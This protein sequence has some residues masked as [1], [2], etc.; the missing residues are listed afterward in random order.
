[1]AGPFDDLPDAQPSA[2]P[3]TEY[4]IPK[5]VL[6][7]TQGDELYDS[8]TAQGKGSSDNELAPGVVAVNPSVHPIGTIFKDTDTN[9]VFI[10]ADKHGN[11]NPNVVDIYTPPSQYKGAS[12]QRN[13]VTIG[14]IPASKI[15]KTASGVA[16]LLSGYGSVPTGE[17]AYASLGKNKS[18]DPFADLP[19]AQQAPEQKEVE[20][21]VEAGNIDL[22]NRPVVKNADGSISTV[23]SISM[24][25][26]K[27]EVLIPTVSED[28]RIM[29]NEEA[30]AQYKKTGK[31]LGTFSSVDAANKYAQ[32]LHLDQEKQYVGVPQPSVSQINQADPFADLPDVQQQGQTQAQQSAMPPANTVNQAN[33]Y[34]GGKPTEPAKPDVGYLELAGRGLT[35]AAAK[36]NELMAQGLGIF[37]YVEDKTLQAFGVNSDIYNRYMKAVHA[38]GLGQPG[39]EA[40][41]IKPTEKLPPLGE[42]VY[43]TAEM[44]GTLPYMMMTGGIGA[45]EA[46]ANEAFQ[47]VKPLLP[48]IT[49]G[50]QSMTIPAAES[51]MDAVKE[52][53]A[54]GDDQITQ[55]A[56]GMAMATT[57]AVMGAIPL[58][59]Q[60]KIANP[61]YRFL[62]Q[63]A[64]GYLTGIPVGEAQKQVNSWV[65]GQPYIPSTFKE[66][67]VQ[68]IPMGLMTGV[69]GVVHAPAE[70][71]IL[72]GPA[73]EIAPSSNPVVNEREAQINAAADAQFAPPEQPPLQPVFKGKAPETPAPVGDAKAPAADLT[74]LILDQTLYDEGSAKWNEIQAQI[75]ALKKPAEAPAEA[76]EHE[77]SNL[78]NFG[79][80]MTDSLYKFLW[81]KVTAGEVTEAGKPSAVLTAAKR[82]RELGG[83][84][85]INEL[86]SFANEFAGI[87]DLPKEQRLDALNQ[88][89]K[90]YTK[91]A[92]TSAQ[93]TQKNA[94]QEPS[95]TETLLRPKVTGQGEVVELSGVGE[96]KPEVPAK[97]AEAPKEEVKPTLPQ[98]VQDEF[99]TFARK[100]GGLNKAQAQKALIEYERAGNIIIGDNGEM[101]FSK[102]ENSTRESLRKAAGIEEKAPESKAKPLRDILY[103]FENA[104]E[105]DKI[106]TLKGLGEEIRDA[107][108]KTKSEVLA[109]L[110]TEIENDVDAG[111][112]IGDA[113]KLVNRAMAELEREAE[114]MDAPK[115]KKAPT[116]KKKTK[117]DKINSVFGAGANSIEPI[118]TRKILS[119]SA[120]KK[121]LDAGLIQIKAGET[122]GNPYDRL[123]TYKI[124]KAAKELI[125][126]D[127]GE[128]PDVMASNYMKVDTP[129]QLWQKVIEAIQTGKAEIEE[130]KAR[131]KDEREAIEYLEKMK[132]LEKDDPEAHAGAVEDEVRKDL[133]RRMRNEGGYFTL[134][135]IIYDA[136][137][138]VGRSVG[139]VARDFKSWS[140]E[141]VNRLGEGVRGF[142]RRIYNAVSTGGGRFLERGAER[143]AIDFAGEERFKP[144]PPT[145][146]EA[147]A[148]KAADAILKGRGTPITQDELANILARKFPGISPNE[149]TDLYATAS[150]TPKAPNPYAG[151]A[152][153]QETLKGETTS[154]KNAAAEAETKALGLPELTKQDEQEMNAAMDRAKATSAED[155]TAGQRL[156]ESIIANPRRSL[157]GDES[158]LLL[159]YKT[160][161]FNSL[162]KMSEGLTIG[163]P[164]QKF[165]KGLAYDNASKA[166]RDLLQA[167]KDRGSEWGREGRWRQ[168]L[169]SQDYTFATQERLATAAKRKPLTSSEKTK[170]AEETKRLTD[171]DKEIAE[172]Q[173]R[174]ANKQEQ[175]GIEKELKNAPQ[176]D[177]YIQSI[178]DRIKKNVSSAA[179]AARDRIK[180][181]RA[182]GRLFTGVDPTDIAD[183]AII[184]ADHLLEGATKFSDWSSRMVSEFGEKIRPYLDDIFKRSKEY[185][186]QQ[187]D[188]ESKGSKSVK[189][190]I[191]KASSPEERVRKGQETRAR[192]RLKQLKQE[193][194]RQNKGDFSKPV[195]KAPIEPSEET[196]RLRIEAQ[197][198][199]DRIDK[200]R[201]DFEKANRPFINKVLDAI[202]AL[203]RFNILSHF[204][205]LE[206][207]AGAAVENIV[208]R[209]IS[210]TLS[211]IFR[212]NKTLNAIRRKAVYEGGFSAKSELKGVYGIVTSGKDV[213][214]KLLKGKT[215]I[216]WLYGGK[217]NY[218]PSFVRAVENIHGMMK[219]PI[220]QGIFSRSL[221][222][223]VEAAEKMGLD[224]THDEVLYHTLASEAVNDANMDIFM[225]DNF[226][227]R[228]I[229]ALMKGFETNK[230]SPRLGKFVSALMD[231][232]MPV[233]NVPTNIAIRKMRLAGGILEAGTRIGIAAKEGKLANGAEKLTNQE[234]EQIM[235]A[236]KYGTLGILIGAYAWNN[237]NQFGGIINNVGPNAPENKDLKKGEMELGGVKIARPL[238]HGPVATYMN[239]VADARRIYDKSVRNNPNSKWSSLSEP[240]FFSMFVSGLGSMPPA[241]A[242]TRFFSPFTTAGQKVGQTVRD[243][244]IAGAVQDIAAKMDTKSQPD[245]FID[246]LEAEPIKRSPKTFEQEIMK[247]IPGL[248]EKVPMKLQKGSRSSTPVL[249]GGSSRSSSSSGLI[250]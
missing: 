177:P 35:G 142:L 238:G 116:T 205:V 7:G 211:Q 154:L 227:T 172:N 64:Y 204:T 78:G 15:P 196:K 150:G 237:A 191:V 8:G 221:Q 46:A 63:G 222:L 83:L 197:K 16:D 247:G 224:P 44:A 87:S 179:D 80:G 73:P 120:Y 123:E 104:G 246:F 212:F 245:N 38:T 241:Q 240:A 127:T 226:I 220:R 67:A 52:S 30:F 85:S 194:E 231:I 168:A 72:G 216:D 151:Q 33:Q 81:D 37:P 62:E 103:R 152:V 233:M 217:N 133:A 195:K 97:E 129:D 24:G 111:V 96:Q 185:N 149:V 56:K 34:A 54:K 6:G 118:L 128:T 124:P 230:Q 107:A 105:E 181:R 167:I 182:E 92:E 159:K 28:G 1:M 115:G 122:K 101:L 18:E 190:R 114:K 137:V 68:A 3:V 242:A 69:F 45:E 9:Q 57:T 47:A 71:K 140:G 119:P 31:N 198:I 43:A 21:L 100:Q 134:P 250:K 50:I 188:K 20:G 239:M 5:R 225:G 243:M 49:Q 138:S 76:P 210:S 169:L 22:N 109:D 218:A 74:S 36:A 170:L 14:S 86:K 121:R 171:I 148:K 228:G 192:N 193:E 88:L 48:R 143:G 175:N 75:D 162:N 202:S 51:G 70:N 236:F 93:P 110:A 99:T 232:A 19:D 27:G 126:S 173:E 248:R 184:G 136:A 91:P 187:A 135:E 26:D 229:R 208:T 60:S 79:S 200:R 189:K 113:Q 42:A 29:S 213:L 40:A 157:T 4:S 130:T 207:L 163:S 183:Y 117:K 147:F 145:E 132:Q 55:I 77:L 10:A 94:I 108:N 164:E 59:M 112:E 249:G 215:D 199:K 144:K 11:K 58:S 176:V 206:H 209:P 165:E 82:L 186:E 244:L 89:A 23:R 156:A 178:V 174:E 158:A 235:R 90:K 160:D 95:T 125:F 53:A 106:N 161:L 234:A 214:N 84:N 41:K 139:K 25:T 13:L 39:V 131:E 65:N 203:N 201:A 155:P 219:E 166:Y 17:G 32:Q 98:P 180:Q 61:L 223:R 66:M 141:M 2:T 146:Q 153:A 12:G 102:P